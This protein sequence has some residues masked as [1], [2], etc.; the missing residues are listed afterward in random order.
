L[1][2]SCQPSTLHPSQRI[3]LLVWSAYHAVAR[4]RVRNCELRLRSRLSSRARRGIDRTPGRVGDR[5]LNRRRFCR[6]RNNVRVANAVFCSAIGLCRV[7]VLAAR[8]KREHHRADCE[9]GSHCRHCF[10]IGV[11]LPVFDIIIFG[12]ETLSHTGDVKSARMLARLA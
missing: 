12:R 6:S 1:A 9:S 3:H 5:S 8:C 10:S 7:R 11:I 4:R 2:V